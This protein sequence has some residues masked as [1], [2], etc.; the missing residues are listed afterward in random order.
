MSGGG[1][2]P[3][4]SGMPADEVVVPHQN[5]LDSGTMYFF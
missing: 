2:A 5:A 4:D 1:M 3:S